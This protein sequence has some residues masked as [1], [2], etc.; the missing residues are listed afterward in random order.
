MTAR[1][2]MKS[3][4]ASHWIGHINAQVVGFIVKKVQNNLNEE[5]GTEKVLIAILPLNEIESMNSK[6]SR[7]HQMSTIPESVSLSESL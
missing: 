2:R 6:M 5:T 3:R 4:V 7:L 1:T